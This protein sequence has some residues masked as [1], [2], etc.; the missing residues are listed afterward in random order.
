M[1]KRNEF[2]YDNNAVTDHDE[3][4]DFKP[5]LQN[6]INTR[7]TYDGSKIEGTLEG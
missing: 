4:A 5:M 7:C 1:D 3:D 6:V 2:E